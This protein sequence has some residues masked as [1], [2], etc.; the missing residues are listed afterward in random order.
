M[1]FDIAVAGVLAVL[2]GVSSAG[3][4]SDSPWPTAGRVAVLVA[5]GLSHAAV[6]AR[7][8]A[9]VAAYGV[10][11]AA[12]L[13]IVAAPDLT[14]GTGAAPP[15][16]LPSSMVFPVLLYAVAAYGRRPWPLVGLGVG[17]VGAAVTTVRVWTFDWTANG[18][19]PT[20]Q[21]FVPAALL[22]IVLAA[23]G[24]GRFR[25]A[26]TA[27]REAEIATLE[28][29]AVRAEERRAERAE[30]AAAA[31][32]ARI[33]REMHDVVAH[34]LAVIVR[35][36]DGGRF[37][38]A[39]DPEKA[40]EVLGVIATTGRQAL[41]DMRAVLG[42]LRSSSSASADGPTPTVDDL[43]ALVS[44]VAAAGTPVTLTTTGE[45]GA[46]DTAASLAAYRVVQEALTNVVRHAA[47]GAAARVHLTWT[48]DG[49]DVAITDDGATPSDEPV[50]GNGLIGMRERV[51]AVGGRLTAGPDGGGFA[52]RAFVPGS[53]A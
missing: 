46:L 3:L 37:A 41:T 33:A 49:L 27:Y 51:T 1:V 32:R 31:E 16:L 2:L 26:R 29:R 40:A 22:A 34:S 45:P 20:L 17:L 9:P 25:A 23:W 19:T 4:V 35:Q 48:D 39:T 12:M 18:P 8:V 38:A 30:Q 52:V 42:V 7:R 24:L 10:C 43:P 14:D 5:I 28:E 47:T 15:I 53:P 50:E 44:R 6:A 36:A 11:C 21:L 13:V